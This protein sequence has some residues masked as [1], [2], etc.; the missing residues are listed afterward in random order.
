[1][2]AERWVESGVLRLARRLTREAP[3]SVKSPPV[4]PHRSLLMADK[5]ASPLLTHMYQVP[6]CSIRVTH[7][8]INKVCT[9]RTPQDPPNGGENLRDFIQRI[10]WPSAKVPVGFF[11]QNLTTPNGLPNKISHLNTDKLPYP[12][13]YQPQRTEM[14]KKYVEI[15][16]RIKVGEELRNCEKL[17]VAAVVQI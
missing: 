2:A 10:S 13:C 12:T 6:R 11:L 15:K 8:Q 5:A 14:L 17:N 7:V 4:H 9:A 16:V 1:M 3:L